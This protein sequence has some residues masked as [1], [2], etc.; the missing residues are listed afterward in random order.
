[1]QAPAKAVRDFAEGHR[2]RG[3]SSA[4]VDPLGLSARADHRTLRP[5]LFGL[6]PHQALSADDAE[7]YGVPDVEGLDARLKAIYCGDLA[8]DCSAVRD[9]ARAAWCFEAFE[10]G[11]AEPMQP[12]VIS[13]ALLDRLVAAQAWEERVAEQHPH[14]KRFS[15]EGCESLIPLVDLLLAGA[16]QQGVDQ[17]V[18]GMPHRGRVNLLVNVMGL[19]AQ[20]VLGYF[21][22]VDQAGWPQDLVYHLG[23]RHVVETA[24]GKVDVT[25]AFNPSHLQSVFP[26][27]SGMAHAARSSAGEDG[28][29]ALLIALHGDAAFAGQGV[30]M[31]TLHLTRHPGYDIGGTVHIVINNQVG[32][33]APHPMDGAQ[34]RYC[35]DIARMVDA[36]VLRVNADAPDQLDRAVGF[37]LAYR[38]RFKADVLIDL[39]GYRRHGHSEHD[40]QEL[41]RPQ[42]AQRT[43]ERPGVVQAYVERA[44][45]AGVASREAL[46]QCVD[47][48]RAAALASW[49]RSASDHQSLVGACQAAAPQLPTRAG[50]PALDQLQGWLRSMAALPADFRPH[51]KVE[52]LRQ[53]WLRAAGDEAA[54]VDW[55][56]AEN[57]AYASLLAVGVPVRISGM[58]VQRGTFFHRHAVWH[59]Q[60]NSRTHVPLQQLGSGAASLTVVNSPLAEE[61]VLG[62]E[63]GR[64]VQDTCTLA[65]W[66]AQFGDFVNEAQVYLD[67]YLSS[68][69]AKW[70]QTAALGVLLPHGYEGNGPEHSTGYLSRFLLLC[71]DDNLRVVC[72][73]TA[74]QWFH[75]L[76]QQ[77]LDPVRKP[78]IALTPKGS[79]YA[80]AASHGDLQAL[81]RGGFAP[82][83]GDDRAWPAEQVRRVV[84]SSGKLHYDL[85]CGREEL[86]AHEVALWRLEQFYPFP[87]LALTA[88]LA[89]HP[90]VKELVWAQEEHLNQGAWSGIRDELTLACRARG[91]RVRCVSR[92][93]NAAGATASM[94]LHRCE[95][96]ELVLGAL[97]SAGV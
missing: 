30:V 7:R 87:R 65:L 92:V 57:L 41:T 75:L 78:L 86:Q 23:R 2:Q 42:M 94:E 33:T 22:G 90:Q 32:F 81:C 59:D 77:A 19:P 79:L 44:V 43:L 35:T 73:S 61:A 8:L 10:A 51:A 36:P 64:S 14:G 52:D 4:R 47:R 39:V 74:V 93:A 60:T 67:Q 53:R 95:Q 72:P 28:P 21:A 37:A 84:L 31:E 50:L 62:F 85:A 12:S 11:M 46:V 82:L 89:A 17:V 80:E 76:R 26:V 63:Y 25:L 27:V 71:G 1:M 54:P 56:L 69:E 3:H 5:Q 55:C 29:G 16:A 91:I 88:L 66:E 6:Y 58:D 48:A 97:S 34:H 38:A 45:R 13:R 49:G 15:L 40:V 20:E 83:L 68:G 18:L 70:G 24:E 9:A 96:R